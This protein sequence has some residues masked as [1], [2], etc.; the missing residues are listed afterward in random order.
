MAKIKIITDTAADIMPDVAAHNNIEVMPI[1]IA[2]D[3]EGYREGVDFSKTEF[4]ERLKNAAAIPVTSQV[5]AIEYMDA[6][7]KCFD[8]GYDEVIVVTINSK[9]SGM[10]NSALMGI[11]NLTEE[12]PET[13]GKINIRVVDSLNYSVMYGYAVVKAAEMVRENKSADEIVAYL[14]DFFTRVQSIFTVFTLDYA[15]KSG[16]ISATA[17]F[18]GEKLGL[19]PVMDITDGAISVFD[20]ARGDK[21]TLARMLKEIIALK[22]EPKSD[23]VMIYGEDI[24]PAKQ[25]EE[26]IKEHFGISACGYCQIGASVTINAGPKL[27]GVMIIGKK[28]R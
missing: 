20:K 18:V 8:E 11:S 25:L 12:Y 2:I 19:R 14:E 10:Y 26:M 28:R 21:N 1:P 24:E 5:T 13:E 27:C 9:G 17:A 16:R 4:Y 7:K 23:Y 22:D 3:G 6:Y 15:K